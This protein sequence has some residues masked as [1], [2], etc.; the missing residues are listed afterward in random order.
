MQ[1][2]R[3]TGRHI[4]V[5]TDRQEC[6][7]TDKNTRRQTQNKNNKSQTIFYC[8]QLHL[9]IQ[10]DKPENQMQYI[11]K[12]CFK[13]FVIKQQMLENDTDNCIYT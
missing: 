1:T 12:Q 2:D 6:K 4:R 5:Y 13:Y 3:N 7:Q 8:T 10:N 11:Q 9:G